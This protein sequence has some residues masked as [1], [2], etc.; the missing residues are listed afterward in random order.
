MNEQAQSNA[1]QGTPSDQQV[2]EQIVRN[3]LMTVHT[4]MPGIVHTFNSDGTADIQ[5]VFLYKPV[6]AAPKAYPLL[7]HVPLMFY[8]PAN[9][10]LRFPVSKNDLVEL[11]FHERNL[12]SF[13]ASETVEPVDPASPRLFHLSDAV[14][15][16]G[17]RTMA[18]PVTPLGDP[19]SA[20]LAFGSAWI[21]I[22]AAGK[23]KAK[24]GA[25]NTTQILNDLV[26]LIANAT[27]SPSGGA[28]IFVSPTPAEL[29]T[30]IGKVWA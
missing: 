22:T 4:A 18:Q 20:E 30:E 5:P 8:G 2:I 28:L 1:A 19:T 23:F 12:D 17:L 9:G 16:P 7:T 27:S 29:T 13:W 21:E 15:T 25:G 24:N 6:N 26:S 11:H 3:I 10:W 14:A